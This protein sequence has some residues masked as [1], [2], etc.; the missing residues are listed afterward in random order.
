M[1]EPMQE[2][3]LEE[4]TRLVGRPL[5]VVRDALAGMLRVVER[6]FR[7]DSL[8]GFSSYPLTAWHVL[9]P[10]H[11]GAR[12]LWDAVAATGLT[13]E[14][15]FTALAVVDDHVRRGYGASAWS[16]AHEW[17]PRLAGHYELDLRDT[18]AALRRA[19]RIA[20]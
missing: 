4:L 8:I 11:D 18:G 13:A 6:D 1:R 19:A 5:P 2:N 17:G 14:E 16:R 12:R 7:Q 20:P 10:G 3:L 15:T 9:A